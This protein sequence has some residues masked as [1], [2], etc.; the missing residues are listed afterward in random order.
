[1]FKNNN[2]ISLI[3]LIITIIVIIILASIAYFSGFRT[4]E[5]AMLSKFTEEIS[6]LRTSVATVRANNAIEKD[7]E[8]YG[9]K[10]VH[11]VNAPDRFISFSNDDSDKTGYLVDISVL[12]YKPANRGKGTISGDQVN[13]GKDDVYV[14]DKNGAIYYVGGFLD[15][16]KVYYNAITFE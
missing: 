11:L 2:G 7:D 1:M 14:Y 15:D 4:P 10:Y 16:G 6:N 13:F 3:S 9:F 12:D 8:N 5:T